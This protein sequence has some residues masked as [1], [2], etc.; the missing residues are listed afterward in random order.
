M[1]VR[2]AELHVLHVLVVRVQL[3]HLRGAVGSVDVLVRRVDTEDF[4][5]GIPPRIA[6]A[7]LRDRVVVRLLIPPQHALVHRERA[8]ALMVV[9]AHALRGGN[10]AR[11]LVFDRVPVL[12][13]RDGLVPRER[14]PLVAELGEVRGV[15]RLAVVGVRDFEGV[16]AVRAHEPEAGVVQAGLLHREVHARDLELGAVVTLARAE[17]AALED[18]EGVGGN[19]DLPLRHRQQF[20]Q[21]AIR[22]VLRRQFTDAADARRPVGRLT[23][24]LDRHECLAVHRDLRRLVPV[25]V[26]PRVE[27]H[28]VR[29]HDRAA[30]GVDD[31]PVAIAADLVGH[32][33]VGRI[34]EANELRR[35]EIQ[36]A[37][38]RA[39]VRRIL[40]QIFLTRQHVRLVLL[41][42]RPVAAMTLD[43][44]KIDVLVHGLDARMTALARGARRRG[45]RLRLRASRTDAGA[46]EESAD[47]HGH[48]EDGGEN[49][50]HGEPA[51]GLDAHRE[52]P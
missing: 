18:P 5:L 32:A 3:G 39:R 50:C 46:G 47:H 25:V 17:V 1:P 12:V 31:G 27:H 24:L 14:E 2:V 51:T 28:R 8:V 35:L 6:H 7:E 19:R 45:G 22:D 16:G 9:A 49:A 15:R 21:D 29:R 43:A 20:V 41:A 37:V 42:L 23:V 34:H 10:A 4:L 13:L 36:G 30:N 48:R 33:Q 11:E 26:E 40:E 52:A 38:R 44:S